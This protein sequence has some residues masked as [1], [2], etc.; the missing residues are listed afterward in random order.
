MPITSPTINAKP[1][2][3]MAKDVMVQ[4]KNLFDIVICDAS[5]VIP[6]DDAAVLGPHVDGALLVV[7]AG[8]TDRMVVKR[9]I[10]ILN[11]AKVEILGIVLNNMHGILPYYYDYKYY[12]Y[13]ED[14]EQ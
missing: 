8:K 12:G 6:V 2:M 3:P 9:A 4:C 11:D 10:E 7:M 13:R 1:T 14:D 5:P